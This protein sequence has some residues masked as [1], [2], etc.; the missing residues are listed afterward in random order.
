MASGERLMDLRSSKSEQDI[1][2]S[3]SMDRQESSQKLGEILE[4]YRNRLKRLVELRIDARVRARVDASDVLQE[5]H[6]EAVQRYNKYLENPEV[7]VYIWLRYL[8]LQKVSQLH[9]KHLG[10]QARNANREISIER[11]PA[12]AN[13]AILAAQLVGQMTTA[14]E[15][16]ARD[17]MKT[18]LERALNSMS[19]TDREVLALRHFEQL[20]QK[21][22]AHVLGIE[23][24][25]AGARYLRALAKLRKTISTEFDPNG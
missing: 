9:Q 18:R 14:S 10:V 17:E 6:I 5:T 15:A 21:E 2:N 23:E 13:S 7:P 25:A 16:F 3:D 11:E 12:P 24:K 20:S 1:A 22:T 19:K 4:Q 8:T